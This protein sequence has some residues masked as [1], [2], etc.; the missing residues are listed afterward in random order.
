MT[1]M[2]SVLHSAP[3]WEKMAELHDQ[4]GHADEAIRYYALFIERWKDADPILQPRV[5]AGRTRMNTLLDLK[6]RE[7]N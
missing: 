5:D 7:P 2:L 3:A 4:L 6:A 1:P